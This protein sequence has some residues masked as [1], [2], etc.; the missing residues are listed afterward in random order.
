MKRAP[1][2]VAHRSAPP[3][4]EHFALPSQ[5]TSFWGEHQ[6]LARVKGRRAAVNAARPLHH[7]QQEDA[8]ASLKVCIG[9]QPDIKGLAFS[10]NELTV[11]ELF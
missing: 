5:P 6:G 11:R 7:T 3:S 8:E 1:K 2:V 10:D 9:P 4:V